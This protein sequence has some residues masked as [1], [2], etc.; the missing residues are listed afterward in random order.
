MAFALL[1]ELAGN[2]LDGFAVTV[3]EIVVMLWHGM[4]HTVR[5]DRQYAPE[6]K[7]HPE[8]ITVVSVD[9]Q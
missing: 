4:V 1:F 2:A 7:A 5:D 8:A 3:A 9:G 6:Q